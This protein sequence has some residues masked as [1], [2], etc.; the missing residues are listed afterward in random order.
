LFLWLSFALEKAGSHVQ[1]I[2]RPLLQEPIHLVTLNPPDLTDRVT[3]ST[4]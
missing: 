2:Q 1:V 3:L 4:V